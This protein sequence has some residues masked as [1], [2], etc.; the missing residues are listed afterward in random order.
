MELLDSTNTREME[1]TI[2]SYL[3]SLRLGL[4]SFELW[5]QE[6]SGKCNRSTCTQMKACND[7]TTEGWNRTKTENKFS[8]MLT[9]R[10]DRRNRC[11][12]E[13]HWCYNDHN[14]LNTVAHRMSDRRHHR[15]NHVRHLQ[16]NQ[17]RET[18]RYWRYPCYT[19]AATYIGKE[20]KYQLSC[21]R[22]DILYTRFYRS[23]FGQSALCRLDYDTMLR[24]STLATSLCALVFLP[25]SR[26]LAT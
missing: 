12:E 18:I 17:T 25:P 26:P 20:R 1:N 24:Q 6:N 15:Q 14:T 8:N 10:V 23:Y 4:E 2:P 3:R 21:I 11:P 16:Q 9:E 22:N 19:H 13:Q 7:D 5:V